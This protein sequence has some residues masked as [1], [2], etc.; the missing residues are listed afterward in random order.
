[1]HTSSSTVRN[2]LAIALDTG[3]LE[4]ALTIAKAVQPSVG[5][6]KVGLQLF[7]AAGH[8]AV[9]AIQDIGMDVFLDVK[10]HDI[11]NTVYGASTVLGSLGVQ[12]LTV[13]AAGG[14]AMLQ[15]A[16]KGLTEGAD[17]AGLP[18]PTVLAVTVLTSAPDAS[19]ALLQERLSDAVAA[20]CG[21]VVCAATDLSTIRSA[22]PDILTV[23]PGIRP[24][25]SP[26]HDQQRIATP[27]E[28]IRSGANILVLGRAVTAADNPAVAA[29]AIAAEVAQAI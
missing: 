14:K 10:L 17:A 4:N 18:T 2:R 3:D 27:A 20:N 12:Y 7:S 6:A 23:V 13:H 1:M 9:R 15:A 16:V 26:V 19:P 28:A 5:V 21:G 8:D 25:G 29:E 24:A 11:P 22:A